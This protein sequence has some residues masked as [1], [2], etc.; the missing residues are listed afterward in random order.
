MT[1]PLFSAGDMIIDPDQIYT[2]VKIEN[3]R[4]FY[5]PATVD[6]QNNYLCSIP[7]NNLK[8]ACIRPL[9]TKTEV[10]DLLKNLSHEKP[11]ELPTT[12]R[13]QIN[14]GNFFKDIIYKNDP[15]QTGRMLIYF[16][17]LEKESKLSRTDQ[18]FYDQSLL[19]LAQEVSF[20]TNISVDVAK[21]KI[22]RA[23]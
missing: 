4:I 22:L 16:F 23:L 19:H 8:L 5:Q 20:V 7:E 10:V 13:S 1:R 18:N 12:S 17:T 3:G 15:Y 6:A 9:L 14:N 11:V 21:E 2:I